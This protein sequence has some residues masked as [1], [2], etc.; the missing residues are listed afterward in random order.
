MNGVL[1]IH[2]PAGI[3]SAQVVARVKRLLGAEKVGHTGTLD[4]FAGGVLVCCVNQ[5]TR[6][7]RF[8][9]DSRKVYEGVITLG[10]ET[11]TQDATGQVTA[12]CDCSG[13]SEEML[14]R[15]FRRHEGALHQRPPAYSALKHQ[16]VPLYA[17]ARS[18]RPVQKPPR[19]VQVY[20]LRLMSARLP[21]VRFDVSCSPGTYIRTLAA[22]IGRELGC[23]GHL[24]E[25][26]RLET[27]G[28]SLEQ[29]VG[30]EELETLARE[31]AAGRRL[32]PMAEALKGLP[33][34]TAGPA[35]LETIRHGRLLS[36]E[37]ADTGEVPAD[38]GA[39]ERFIKVVDTRGR[40]VAVL[41]DKPGRGELTYA[42]V[43]A[44][45]EG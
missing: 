24:S 2:K 4:P 38:T 20:R 7:A 31:G 33:E 45:P 22:D 8:L 36:R 44:G 1:V 14:A 3:S 5:A 32:I 34:I 6:L 42:C 43:F 26:V 29:A 10:V 15:V 40:L 16:G 13:V 23:G 11:D 19:P 18:G 12:E 21:L 28:F 37:E 30:L 25:L 35:L 41:C 39:G 9:M 17:L 27:G